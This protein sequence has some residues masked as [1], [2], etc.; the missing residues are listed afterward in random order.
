LAWGLFLCLLGGMV[1]TVQAADIIISSV[2]DP[3]PQ[4]WSGT[5]PIQ[6]TQTVCVGWT[7]PGGAAQYTITATGTGSAGTFYLQGPSPVATDVIPYTV[8]WGNSATST[9]GISLTPGL[10]VAITPNPRSNTNCKSVNTTVILTIQASDLQ[11]AIA[12]TYSGILSMTVQP[13]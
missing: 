10:A 8:Q 11:N 7:P 5:G 1:S 3:A 2:L 9:S 12:G 6:L 4:K 13:L